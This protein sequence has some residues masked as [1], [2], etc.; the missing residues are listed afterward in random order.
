MS[1][2]VKLSDIAADLGYE[3][4]DIVAKALELDISVKNATSKVSVEDAGAIYDY[5]T[6]GQIPKLILDRRSSKKAENKPKKDENKEKAKKPSEL[7][8]FLQCEQILFKLLNHWNIA[9][10]IIKSCFFFDLIFKA[11]PQ[12]NSELGII[13]ATYFFD[14]S[15]KS[16]A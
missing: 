7:S 12:K 5:I 14:F 1:N 13:S 6:S 9:F 11:F 15:T 3:A 8:C 16:L 2:T 10:E 4:K